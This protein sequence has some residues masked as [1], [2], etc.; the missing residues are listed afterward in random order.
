MRM[1]VTFA[2]HIPS[3]SQGGYPG[4]DDPDDHNEEDSFV[5]AQ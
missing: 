3:F 1:A 5:Q 4:V 2:N